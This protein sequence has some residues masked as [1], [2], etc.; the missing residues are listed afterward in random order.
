MTARFWRLYNGRSAMSPG[1]AF[2]PDGAVRFDLRSGATSDARG[3]RLVLVPSTAFEALERTTPAV[4]TQLGAEIGR[5]AGARVAARLGGGDGVRASTLEIVVAHLAGEL[6]LTGLGVVHLERYNR[7]L[8]LVVTNAVL[9]S[10]AFVGAILSG[11]IAAA[12]GREVAV[13]AIGRE[14][15]VARYFVG[16]A[17]TVARVRALLGEG[18]PWTEVLHLLHASAGKR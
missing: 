7:A 4:L 1:P 8:V 11:A 16:S 12:A 18:R 10:D 9:A 3:S 5:A 14:G 13:G 15:D 6:A 2:D 17:E